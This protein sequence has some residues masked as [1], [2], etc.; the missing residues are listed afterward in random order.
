MERLV[1]FGLGLVLTGCAPRREA[2]PVPS[3][4]PAQ[5]TAPSP[6][7]PPPAAGAGGRDAGVPPIA[8]GAQDVGKPAAPQFRTA[9]PGDTRGTIACGEVRCRAGKQ[10]C[11]GSKCIP[12]SATHDY[13]SSDEPVFECDEGSDCPA[14]TV[15]CQLHMGGGYC[16][17]RFGKSPPLHC[18]AEL[19]IPNAGAPC[20]TGESCVT[21]CEDGICESYCATRPL[22][23]TYAPGKRCDADKGVL[24]WTYATATG[25]CVGL[26]EMERLYQTAVDDERIG[27]FPCT[28]P[29]DCAS[30]MR[31]VAAGP[32]G[33]SCQPAGE[34]ANS[35]YVCSSDADCRKG[36]DAP[37]TRTKCELAARNEYYQDYH[38]P[39]WMSVCRFRGPSD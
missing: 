7:A 31:C 12:L 35:T 17:P 25:K 3:K 5:S 13:D 11:N 32:R 16:Q 21:P 14:G 33:T 2:V 24:V 19:C 26:E 4:P 29:S 22:R 10:A 23:A 36:M 34:L 1:T 18:N 20:P 38:Y 15:C 8:S 9:L 27:I 39:P 37:F 30:A 28:R 6:T